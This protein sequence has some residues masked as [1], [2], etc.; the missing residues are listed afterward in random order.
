MTKLI[1]IIELSNSHK[2]SWSMWIIDNEKIWITFKFL[3]FQNDLLT[4]QKNVT[5]Y[6]LLVTNFVSWDNG[7][8]SAVNRALD[9]STYPG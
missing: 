1:E 7:R 3:I 5:I 6:L 2:L 4:M 9:G 8:G